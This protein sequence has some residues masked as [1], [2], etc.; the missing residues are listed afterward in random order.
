MLCPG[1]GVK[2]K[3]PLIK[4]PWFI[5]LLF[6]V[7]I[8]LIAGI[9][10]WR[11]PKLSDNFGLGKMVKLKKMRY[12]APKGWKKKKRA[13]SKTKATYVKY[14]GGRKLGTFVIQYKG[15]IKDC[16]QKKA[17][18]I[19][20]KLYKK[21][22]NVV[23]K[24][25][26]SHKWG[27]TNADY[28][29]KCIYK[30]RG[31]TRVS[32]IEYV[33]AD[34]T[35]FIFSTDA[36]RAAMR[37]SVLK[38]LVRASNVKNYRNPAKLKKIT[39]SYKGSSGKG[40]KIDKNSKIVVKARY[41]DGFRREVT[42]WKLEGADTLKAGKISRFTVKYKGKKAPLKIVCTSLT[43]NQ[44]AAYAAALSY[45]P[46]MPYSR[47]GLIKQLTSK[48]GDHF[49][50]SDAEIA[51]SLM[52]QRGEVDWNK[53][54]VKAAREYKTTMTF[55]RDEMLDWMQSEY[56]AGFTYKQAVHGVNAVYK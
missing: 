21:N 20:K 41:S 15:R 12:R 49:S 37:H 35:L 51:V 40:T 54:A 1:C 10:Y 22:K 28:T 47:S 34:N 32:D 44:K 11:A 8:A 38:K 46:S 43:E 9:I 53:Q 42:G 52:E 23:I 16:S 31:R 13:S 5:L 24:G 56:G 48:T 17:E 2:N 30:S 29:A 45:L 33:I 27:K 55:S 3:K 25:V 7:I 4:R 36:R 39:A 26:K 14:S 19:L 18:E 6:A 50:G